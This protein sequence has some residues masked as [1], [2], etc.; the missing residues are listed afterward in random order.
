MDSKKKANKSVD[1]Y[2][3]IVKFKGMTA[4]HLVKQAKQSAIQSV[5]D[6][7]SLVE[8]IYSDGR[9]KIWTRDYYLDELKDVKTEIN[10]IIN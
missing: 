4:E 9:I 8:K 10:N 7:I 5:D 6:Q 2:I 3:W 1:K